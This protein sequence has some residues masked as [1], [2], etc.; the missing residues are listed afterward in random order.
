M[1]FFLIRRLIIKDWYFSRVTILVC[2]L[3]GIIALLMIGIGNESLFYFG[4]VLFITVL[5]GLGVTLAIMT[6]IYER[7]EHTLPLIMSLPISYTEYTTSK[8]LA[9]LLIFLIP[10]LILALG[11]IV[12]VASR[13]T[14]PNG[15]IP[16][17]ILVVTE[18]FVSYCVILSVAIVTES[19]GWTIATIVTSQLYFNYFLFQVS[20]HPGISSVKEGPVAIWGSIVWWILGIELVIVLIA[21]SLTYYL[22]SRK[23]DFI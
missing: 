10:W 6:V 22:Q 8:I 11:S 1:N 7:K 19:E 23:K 17:V 15:M 5:V 3:A 20:N 4:S 12:V 9:N 2:L 21:L 16:F 13:N 14:I 18:I